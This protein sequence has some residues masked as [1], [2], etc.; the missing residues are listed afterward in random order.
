[1]V[2]HN[3]IEEFHNTITDEK[4]TK[5]EF[6]ISSSRGF[7]EWLANSRISLAFTTYKIGR[8][9]FIGLQ[10]DGKLSVFQRS[11]ERCM[12]LYANGSSLYMSSIY[13][14]LKFE[15]ILEKG[16]N[17]DD[18]DSLYAPQLSWI[19][20]DCDIHDISVDDTKNVIFVNTLFNCLAKPSQTHSFTPIWKPPFISD[21]VA[22]D[23]CHLNGLAMQNGK[24][25]FV[26]SV[27]ES[28]ASD[29]WRDY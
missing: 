7:T 11:F 27:S 14:L 13:Q 22:E 19:T 12:G 24:A 16:T 25:Q 15:N 21:L 2:Q 29:G 23:R 20:G 6:S 10:Q 1:M 26:T 9:F 17:H 28:D 4:N 3:N 5:P 8:L 18:Y